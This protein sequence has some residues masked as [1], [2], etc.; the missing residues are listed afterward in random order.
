MVIADMLGK[1]EWEVLEQMPV[2]EYHRW[3]AYINITNEAQRQATRN[4]R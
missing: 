4:S 3:I 2:D 1:F